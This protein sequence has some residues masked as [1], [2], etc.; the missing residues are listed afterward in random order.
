[1]MKKKFLTLVTLLLL[2]VFNSF[3]VKTAD[4][5][6]KPK[7]YVAN[8][9]VFHLSSDTKI[10]YKGNLGA[11]AIYLG[12]LLSPATGWDLKTQQTDEEQT[13]TIFLAIDN[14][15][16]MLEILLFAIFI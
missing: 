4:I 10:L 13:N 5:I 3:A 16:M 8:G 1:M 2:I 14:T 6:P 11:L 15:R 9:Q 12:E 7:K